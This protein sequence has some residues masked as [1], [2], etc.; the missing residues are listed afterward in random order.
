MQMTSNPARVNALCQR[1][2][3][4]LAGGDGKRLLP[5]TRR[6]T[7]DDRPKQFCAVIGDQTLLQQTR[8]RVAR[9]ISRDRTL[10]VLT[11]AHERFYQPEVT[12]AS[13]SLL[14]IQPQ[15]SGTSAAI[16]YSLMRIRTMDS[17]GLVAFF[18]SDH[19]IAD[20]EAFAAQV[21]LA[22]SLAEFY[23]EMVFLLGIVP[24]KPEASYGWIEPAALLQNPYA[25]SISCVSRFWEKPSAVCASDL[26][27]RGCL[28]NSF[29]MVGRADAFLNLAQR[30]IPCLY[31]AFES[32]RQSFSTATEESALYGLYH[33][34]PSSS[35]SDE[36]LTVS[37]QDLAVIRSSG[38]GWSDLGEPER[39]LAVQ[40]RKGPTSER[41]RPI[42]DGKVSY[43]IA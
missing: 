21:D 38:F 39:V 17:S 13:P 10:L 2:G 1:W 18:P 33:S 34:I 19:Y 27:G 30:T 36:V 14:L 6:M 22:F 8:C 20:D 35:F 42:L 43:E 32:V 3:V 28:W 41:A 29:I 31:S 23:P 26:M 12:G 25:E 40:A 11:R 9:M 16:M 24:E 5:L 4:V 7:G 15:N 37:P